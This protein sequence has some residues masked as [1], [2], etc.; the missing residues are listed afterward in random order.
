MTAS[1]QDELRGAYI[2]S[3]KDQLKH[4]MY[5]LNHFELEP[6]LQS[7]KHGE[8]IKEIILYFYCYKWL[9]AHLPCQYY[10][11][12]L[13]Q[14]RHKTYDFLV[15]ILKH[16]P[17]EEHFLRNYILYCSKPE[18][19]KNAPHNLKAQL[20]YEHYNK[21]IDDC[22]SEIISVWKGLGYFK[23]SPAHRL[24]EE[25][26][27]QRHIFDA[28]YS[29]ADRERLRIIDKL[30]IKK[31][32]HVK[33]SH[34]EKLALIPTFQCATGC[35]HCLFI[36]RPLLKPLYDKDKLFDIVNRYTKNV[37][38]TGGDLTKYLGDFYDAVRKMDRIENF[39]ILLNGRFAG[40]GAEADQF[41]KSINEALNE[42]KARGFTNASVTVQISFDEFHQEVLIDKK[43]KFYERVP[44]STS[45][46]ILES[47]LAFDSINVVLL[48]KQNSYNF[49][50]A[51]IKK[52]VFARLMREC[53]KRKREVT[54]MSAGTSR[55]PKVNPV[56]GKESHSMITDIYFVISNGQ[57]KIFTFNSSLVE[58]L[59]KAK[60]LDSTEYV[61][62]R[63]VKDT[64]VSRSMRGENFD[65]DLMLWYNGY[66][67]SFSAP[68]LIL[69]NLY[70]DTI[71][72]I[73]ERWHKDPLHSCLKNFNPELIDYYKEISSDFEQ[74][75]EES[76]SHVNLFMN[77]ICSDKVRLYLT[78]RI[79]MALKE[80]E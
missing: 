72:T 4:I 57:K 59:G 35:R 56:T 5:R 79:I 41:M 54:I 80:Q 12:V 69:G 42:R 17:D 6:G 67:T 21:N 68:H 29:E 39:V 44:V 46:N 19:V 28:I 40:T 30:P 31:H 23:D 25:R 24:S 13:F 53:S 7:H 33:K 32:N 73:I 26:R 51:L 62:A 36:W 8:L 77:M 1:S 76:S 37:L 3:K 14:P 71:E 61:N 22:V 18:N 15:D 45:V 64:S 55:N 78:Q 75:Y 58:A 9:R 70:D 74:I 63:D 52:G 49:S 20:F 38:F 47:S 50:D 34:F 60:F 16:S 43:G 2:E 10:G 66:V 27:R 65:S 48:H 11:D